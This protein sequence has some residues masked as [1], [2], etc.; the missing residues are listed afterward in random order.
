MKMIIIAI[1]LGVIVALVF[2]ACHHEKGKATEPGGFFSSFAKAAQT[3]D[4]LGLG[5][6]HKGG[7]F[8]IFPEHLRAQCGPYFIRTD[9][10]QYELGRMSNKGLVV[11]MQDRVVLVLEPDGRSGFVVCDDMSASLPGDDTAQPPAKVVGS[12]IAKGTA[13]ENPKALYRTGAAADGGLS[14][15]SG[16][17]FVPVDSA[18]LSPFGR[19]VPGVVSVADETAKPPAEAV[20]KSPWYPSAVPGW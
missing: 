13:A 2:R 15:A 16:R 4:R 7:A 1:V 18:P 19:P 12:P 8:D 9:G 5:K 11:K 17:H 14:D 20:G 10:G 6:D 3:P